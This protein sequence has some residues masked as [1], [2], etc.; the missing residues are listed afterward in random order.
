MTMNTSKHRRAFLKGLGTAGLTAG[1]GTLALPFARIAMAEE[2]HPRRA[3]FVFI[4]DGMTPSDWHAQG[5]GTQFTLPGMTQPLDRV[6]EHCLFLNGID[7]YGSGSTHEGGCAKVFTGAAG[8]S[9]DNAVSLDHYLGQAFKSQTI[10]PHL[11]LGIIPIYKNKHITF[12]TNGIAVTPELNPLVA[13]ESLFGENADDNFQNQR[14]LSALDASLAELNTLR[15]RLG[16]VEQAK[17]DGHLEALREL[18]QKLNSDSSGAC[19]AWNFNPTGFEVT[20]TELWRN[21]EYLDSDQLGLIGDLHTDVAVHAL[22]CDLT[23]VVTLKWNNSVNDTVIHETGSSKTCH[24]A[25]HEG[26]NDFVKI[27]AWYTEKLAQLIE[28][29]KAVPEGNGTLLDNT[30]IFL[31]S[32]LA[33]GSWHNHTDMP[34]ILAGGQAGGWS[35]GRSLQYN[36]VPHNKILVS[37]AQFMGVNI[38]QFGTE[39]SAPGALPGLT[40]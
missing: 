8:R 4:P 31:G 6:R 19:P 25:S 10:K 38:N 36:D 2:I 18:E 9:S 24:Q 40:G 39:D 33:N 28:Q 7:M 21:P 27:K 1:L 23:R 3:I 13:F 17:L 22:A 30:V 32:D 15:N 29:L 26:G 37:I 20:R 12:D 34:F 11:N 16:T 14:K 35:T 5:T